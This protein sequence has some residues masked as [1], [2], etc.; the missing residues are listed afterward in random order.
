[1]AEGQGSFSFPSSAPQSSPVL[2]EQVSG[3]GFLVSQLLKAISGSLLHRPALPGFQMS[4]AVLLPQ[5]CASHLLSSHLPPERWLPHRPLVLSQRPRCI[6]RAEKPLVL[7][8][9]L[10]CL[11][12]SL[13][14]H[15]RHSERAGKGGRARALG[16]SESKGEEEEAE[17]PQ[18]EMAQQSGPT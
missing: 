12:D 4:P 11:A 7:P 5:I 18:E 1:M 9:L 14:L 2:I 6:Q 3:L 8:Y 17:G 16:L 10:R 15:P 13:L